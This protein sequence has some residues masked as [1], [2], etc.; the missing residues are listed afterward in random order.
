LR[1]LLSDA[2]AYLRE[3][4][5]TTGRAWNSFFFTPADPTPL[6]LMRIAVGLLGFWSL[7]VF[8]L[9]LHAY[10]GTNGWA[11]P[12]SIRAGEGALTWSFW[13]MVP[14]AWLRPVWLVC[15]G[16]LVVFTFGLLSR[17]TAWLSW[18]IIVSTVRR[19][20]IALFGFDQMLSALA[21]YLAVSG[22]SGQAVSLDRFLRR[23]RESR[24]AASRSARRA[25][26]TGRVVTPQSPGAP[27]TSISAN[28]ALRLIQLHL[29]LI[30]ATA[31]LAKVQGMSWW[32]G[33]AIWKTMATGE[34][35]VLDFTPLASWP[36]LINL[37][38][39]GALA[40]ELLYPVLIWIKIARPLSLGLMLALHAGIG[41]MSPGLTEFALVMIAANLA[42]VS[43]PWIRGL[44]TGQAQPRIRVLYDGAC[45]RCRRSMAL[46]TA[47][48]PDR[49]IEPLDLTAVDVTR[50][51]S[52]LRAKDCMEAMH[53]VTSEGAIVAGFDAV[54]SIAGALPLFWPVAAIGFLP[55]VASIGRRVYNRIAASRPRDV[56]CSDDVCGIHS[57]TP[58]NVP[59]D[60]GHALEPHNATAT[61]A[62]TEEGSRS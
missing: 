58:R 52:R 3:L 17:T 36:R 20:P 4:A 8:G 62:D 12:V 22:A 47:A 55:G 49:V 50:V 32:N 14:D 42:F 16:I 21:F 60:R 9:D 45:P 59:R 40:L 34:F 54:R 26:G 33:T 44:V 46:L 56:A 61:L 19:V 1:R 5:T 48:D 13:F 10:F 31:G 28:I 7:F 23:W 24:E 6:G 57:R 27:P 39:H 29:V 53:A 51:D 35:V 30:Y 37:L 15:L 11:E 41:V 2:A 43:G 25:G 18:I 38:T